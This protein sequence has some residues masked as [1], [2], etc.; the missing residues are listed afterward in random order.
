MTSE[1]PEGHVVAAQTEDRRSGDAP[2][3]TSRAEAIARIIYEEMGFEDD[4]PWDAAVERRKSL[5]M[6]HPLRETQRMCL[7]VAQRIEALPPLLDGG[8]SGAARDHAPDADAACVPS[9]TA[10]IPG[11]VGS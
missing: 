3:S 4:D 11:E 2:P 1:G 7:Q 10:L 9:G 5:G 6:K 8:C